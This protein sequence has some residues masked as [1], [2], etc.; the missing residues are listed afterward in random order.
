LTFA[1]AMVA[2][3]NFRNTTAK[4]ETN[5]KNYFFFIVES[6]ENKCYFL[7]YISKGSSWG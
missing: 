5:Q 2:I 3:G 1:V 6:N 7:L 4:K